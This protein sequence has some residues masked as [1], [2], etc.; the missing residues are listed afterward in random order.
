M[1]TTFSRDGHEREPR[2]V[3]A[4]LLPASDLETTTGG[5]EESV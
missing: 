4:P 1:S 3:A 5:H 2:L